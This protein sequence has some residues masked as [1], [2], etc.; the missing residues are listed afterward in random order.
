M[1]VLHGR[2]AC[3]KVHSFRSSVLLDRKF[4]YL[5]WRRR[6]HRQQWF[7]I[8]LISASYFIPLRI[9]LFSFFS[10]FLHWFLHVLAKMLEANSCRHYKFCCFSALFSFRTTQVLHS[11][12]LMHCTKL[13]AN[14]LTRS[15]TTTTP[16]SNSTKKKNPRN[17]HFFPRIIT[18]S[19]LHSYAFPVSWVGAAEWEGQGDRAKV[20]VCVCA[21]CT[22][23][24]FI[25][26]FA[27]LPNSMLSG[28]NAC[29]MDFL[30]GEKVFSR[31]F[32]LTLHHTHIF[33]CMQLNFQCIQQ[34][35]ISI[36]MKH[37]F[38]VFAGKHNAHTQTHIC[39]H[40][41][42]LPFQIYSNCLLNILFRLLV[43]VTV[44]ADTAA[45][46]HRCYVNAHS[47]WTEFNCK[48]LAF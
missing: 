19:T 46:R 21:V 15:A 37:N 13:S 32:S 20:C 31:G 8:H 29:W 9:L 10:R 28:C 6:R 14:I 35:G 12:W 3:L 22:V 24:E 16:A 45:R 23:A 38:R 44:A 39:R 42:R 48:M 36:N 7:T 4:C 43:A 2:S 11:V 41:K 47:F 25:L 18:A 26:L 33:D 27:F 17:N 30:F 40:K 1:Y 34:N 5:I